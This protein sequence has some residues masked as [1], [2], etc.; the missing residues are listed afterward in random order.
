MRSLQIFRRGGKTRPTTTTDDQVVAPGRNTPAAR[1]YSNAR[2][3]GRTHPE[4][5]EK[6]ERTDRRHAEWWAAER[7]SLFGN[8][9][10]NRAQRRYNERWRKADPT[11]FPAV[12]PRVLGVLPG[13]AIGRAP[14]QYPRVAVAWLGVGDRFVLAGVGAVKVVAVDHYSERSTF[15][16]EN[17]RELGFPVG[18]MVATF[19]AFE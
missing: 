9:R 4:L 1:A 5:V 13:G 15:V 18:A 10:P 17:G 3:A 2:E 16:L 7:V 14:E 11:K 8:R 6:I 12:F 19:E